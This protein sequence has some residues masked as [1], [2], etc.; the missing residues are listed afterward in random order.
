MEEQVGVYDHLFI[1][2]EWNHQPFARVLPLPKVLII[3][4]LMSYWT[5]LSF[6]AAAAATAIG[7][8]S[9]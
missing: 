8:L 5:V 2:R 9:S 6:K 1:S 7:S 3:S 4:V